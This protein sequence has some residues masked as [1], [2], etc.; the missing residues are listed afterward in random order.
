MQVELGL[1]GGFAVSVDGTAVPR[2]A[3]KSR[4]AVQLVA[5]L[6][7]APHRRLAMNADGSGTPTNLTNNPANDN[8]PNWSPD[9]SKIFFSSNRPSGGG[10]NEIWVM[11]ADGSNPVNVTNLSS[12][13]SVPVFSPDGSQIG[14]QEQPVRVDRVRHVTNS[15]NRGQRLAFHGPPRYEN[16]PDWGVGRPCTISGSG[17]LA[18]T[19]GDD[20]I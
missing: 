7:L 2:S 8:A 6:A 4:R 15:V 12:N 19:E 16:E 11:N 3:W 14:V 9:G 5:L 17:D 20:V 13:D 18:G 10:G 1:L